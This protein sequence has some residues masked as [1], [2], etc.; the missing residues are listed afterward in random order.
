[1]KIAVATVDGQQVSQHFGQSRGFFVY[2][3]EEGKIA[4]R[5]LKSAQSTPHE[6]GIC[7]GPGGGIA[8]LLSGCE[9]MLCGGMGG[10]AARSIEQLGMKPM[11]IPGV[12]D[13]DEVV[14]IFCEGRA[15]SVQAGFC[16]CSH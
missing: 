11:V 16:N 4:G 13:P 3:V 9:V 7:K 15:Q 8:E 5:T 2:T 12:I 10:G 1:M 6:A 14:R